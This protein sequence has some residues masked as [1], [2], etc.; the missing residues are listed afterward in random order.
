MS[1]L[2]AACNL[3]LLYSFDY[4]IPLNKVGTPEIASFAG[5]NFAP[6]HLVP[7]HKKCDIR[8]LFAKVT[9]GQSFIGRCSETAK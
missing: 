4:D 9:K 8:V 3:R 7:T 2:L 1:A 5:Q 6:T